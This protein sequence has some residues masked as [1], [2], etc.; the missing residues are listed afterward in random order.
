MAGAIGFISLPQPVAQV[1]L[2]YIWC[3]FEMKIAKISL[4]ENI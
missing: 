1:A 4:N 3:A 2:K